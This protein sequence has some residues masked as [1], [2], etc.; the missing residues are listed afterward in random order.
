MWYV[1]ACGS[2]DVLISALAGSTMDIL[3]EFG[4]STHTS[5]FMD[6]YIGVDVQWCRKQTKG[7][8]LHC[9]HHCLSSSVG[10]LVHLLDKPFRVP[11]LGLL[12]RSRHCSGS[13]HALPSNISYLYLV[14]SRLGA[15]GLS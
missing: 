13:S 8:R 3:S 12:R 6:W 1:S 4:Y 2:I 5:L 14:P 9:H 11:D 10:E 7:S 15:G